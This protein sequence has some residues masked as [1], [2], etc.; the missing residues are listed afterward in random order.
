MTKLLAIRNFTCLFISVVGLFLSASLPVSSETLREAVTRA[1]QNSNARQVAIKTIEAQNKQVAISQGAR[2]ATVDLFGEI[3]PEYT[4]DGTVVG[5][6]V[7]DTRKDTSLSRQAAVSLSYPL[8]DGFRSINQVYKDANTLDAEIIRLSDA[9]ETISLNAVQ[10][11]IDV[12]RRRNIVNISEENITVHVEIARQVEQQVEAGRLSEPD[13]FQA[14][15]KLLA[16]RLA[17]ADAKASLANAISNYQL[18]IGSAP[19]GELSVPSLPN[20]PNSSNTVETNAVR[21]SFLLRI[22]QKDIDAFDYQEAIEAADW[23]P[24][25]DVFLRGGVE[26]D[27][28]GSDGTETT[29]SA[30]LQFNWTLYRGGTRQE[31]IARV[32][33]LKM[34][35]HYRKK[36][37]EDEVR[38]LARSS[39]NSYSAAVERKELLDTTVFN[40]EQIV[41]AFRQEVLAAKRP[42]LEVLD[43]ERSLFNLRVRRANAEAAVAFQQYRMLAAQ[44]SLA[45]HFGLSPFGSNLAADFETRV[46]TEPRGDFNITATPL[47]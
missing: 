20:I 26:T 21:N 22:A 16:A 31:T 42:L 33:D 24:Q 6:N 17:H 18:V 29:L 39:W 37:V 2:R 13:R 28:D 46:R 30:G 38:D 44:S 40:N 23:Q 9:A 5:D 8:L 14:N 12:F 4:D 34:R 41:E 43:A 25:V 19:R 47:E 35:A 1:L 45:R 36:Q 11:Y 27:V 10:A 15:D 7:K 32:R 3:A